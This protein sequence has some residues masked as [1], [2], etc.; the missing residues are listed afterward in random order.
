M[1]QIKG[2]LPC[3]LMPYDTR[4][5]V[6]AEDFQRQVDHI[7]K[8]GCQGAV[9]GQVSEVMRLTQAERYEVAKLLVECNHDRGITIMST[10]GEST[11]AAI[12]YSVQAQDAGI[13]A[14]LLMHPSTTALSEEQMFHYFRDVIKEVDIPV[15]IHHAKSYAK[16]PLSITTQVR[17]LD[18]FGEERIYFKPESSPTP[19]KLSLLRDQSNNRAKIFEGDGGMML[20]DCYKRGLKGTIPAS[21]TARIVNELW[22]ALEAGDLERSRKIA[23]PLSYFMCQMMNSVDCYQFLA[24]HL[25]KRAGLMKNALVRGPHDYIPDQE[26]LR[27]VEITYDH[28]LSLLD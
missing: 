5:N 10:G 4:F 14:L 6:D 22:L 8:S 17:I 20:I 19:P 21:E 25:L 23:Y 27:E 3:I 11:R 9:I 2:T 24:K 28:I 12:D 16:S 15:I 18:E 26:T 7:Y 13:D 1:K